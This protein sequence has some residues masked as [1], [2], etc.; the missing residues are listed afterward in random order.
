[1]VVAT[2]T[3]EGFNA[4]TPVRLFDAS[5]YTSSLGRDG[6]NYD[7]SPD[8]RRFLMVKD[9]ETGGASPSIVVVH[10]GR[11]WNCVKGATRPIPRLGRASRGAKRRNMP[12]IVRGENVRR[13]GDS[14]RLSAC[15]STPDPSGQRPGT[16]VRTFSGVLSRFAERDVRRSPGQ[17][18]PLRSRCAESRYPVPQG[19]LSR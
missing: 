18:G 14:A 6:T 5:A 3:R 8:G 13:L 16:A 15:A 11:S 7:V 19:G 1:M 2:D 17:S 9:V 10:A 4:G 12:T